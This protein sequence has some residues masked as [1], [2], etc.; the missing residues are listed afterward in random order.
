M[1]HADGGVT[2]LLGVFGGGGSGGDGLGRAYR[3]DHLKCTLMQIFSGGLVDQVEAPPFV[4]M[5]FDGGAVGARLG[6]HEGAG[7][8]AAVL[9]VC[10]PCDA[11]LWSR[12]SVWC[13]LHCR[14][15]RPPAHAPF[16]ILQIPWAARSFIRPANG[17]QRE[18]AAGARLRPPR[19]PS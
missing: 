10:D 12:W 1:L 7:A 14:F 4:R 3:I 16:D 8:A 17:R 15:D 11:S 6:A 9:Q 18:Q 5:G 19:L 2:S 13:A